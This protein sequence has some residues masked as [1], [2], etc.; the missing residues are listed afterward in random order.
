M[1]SAA[2]C[3]ARLH[4]STAAS[5]AHAQPR[6]PHHTPTQPAPAPLQREHRHMPRTQPH[7]AHDATEPHQWVLLHMLLHMLLLHKRRR[8]R[9]SHAAKPA[10]DRLHT[11]D[12]TRPRAATCPPMLPELGGHAAPLFGRL[13]RSL[14][15]ANGDR[16]HRLASHKCQNTCI[17][18]CNNTCNNTCTHSRPALDRSLGK[19]IASPP[20]HY[21]TLPAPMPQVTEEKTT[22]DISMVSMRPRALNANALDANGNRELDLGELCA[23]ARGRE[24]GGQSERATAVTVSPS[25]NVTSSEEYRTV[26]VWVCDLIEYGIHPHPGPSVI[27]QNIDGANNLIT[28]DAILYKQQSVPTPSQLTGP[29]VR[30]PG[31]R[32]TQRL[33]SRQTPAGV[34]Q[35]PEPPP[36]RQLRATTG[37]QRRHRPPH[38]AS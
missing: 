17:N 30:N 8:T 25:P 28:L 9:S 19:P 33:R 29:S 22:Q 7:A 24:T 37:I 23:V 2:P 36:H 11:P 31:A 6:A 13:P 35:R 34:R 21:R 3:P 26:S 5:L 4:A 15:S 14:A 20:A 16:P 32:H 18:T 12:G 27:S 38:S 10:C 1:V